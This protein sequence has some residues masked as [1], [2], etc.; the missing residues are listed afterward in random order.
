MFYNLKVIKEN[1]QLLDLL[2]KDT[3]NI[4]DISNI[5]TFSA[6]NLIAINSA[7]NKNFI[8]FNNLV[9]EIYPLRIIT[10]LFNVEPRISK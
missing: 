6:R 10:L 4:N 1:I 2:K 7:F 3:W 8:V 9:I 5:F